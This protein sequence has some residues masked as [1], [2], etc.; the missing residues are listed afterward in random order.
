[1]NISSVQIRAVLD[2]VNIL[3]CLSLLLSIRR[4]LWHMSLQPLNRSLRRILIAGI[5]AF[6][7]DIPPSLTNPFAQGT[8]PTVSMCFS[9]LAIYYIFAMVPRYY[10]EYISLRTAVPGTFSRLAFRAGIIGSIIWIIDLFLRLRE[11]TAV[12]SAMMQISRLLGQVPGFVIECLML[13]LLCRFRDVL[14]GREKRALLFYLLFPPAV[15]ILWFLH[16]PVDL[17]NTMLTVALVFAY[18][19]INMKSNLMLQEQAARDRTLALEARL[20]PEEVLGELD[21]I[22][23]LCLE[24]PEAAQDAIDEFSTHLRGIIKDL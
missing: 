19:E 4:S 9:I 3:V 8:F 20:K 11:E 14:T 12:V 17:F 21:R 18:G 24:D 2:V 5:A 1:M 10:S 22:S 16:P 7:A 13:V 15:Y 6:A 23:G